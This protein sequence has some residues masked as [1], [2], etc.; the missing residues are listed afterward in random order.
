VNVWKPPYELVVARLYKG[1]VHLNGR[2]WQMFRSMERP[3][4]PWFSVSCSF[5]F[6]PGQSVCRWITQATCGQR[7]VCF[8]RYDSHTNNLIRCVTKS[9]KC[10]RL[11]Y[12]ILLG[13]LCSAERAHTNLSRVAPRDGGGKR[14]VGHDILDFC[15]RVLATLG[16]GGHG[17]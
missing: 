11:G 13:R 4:G 17:W 2:I 6:S 15:A 10:P 14:A 12:L 3:T 9:S 16:L 1:G 8:L 5:D 7:S